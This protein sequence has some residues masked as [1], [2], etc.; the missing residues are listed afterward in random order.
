VASDPNLLPA[1]T[2]TPAPT[3]PSRDPAWSFWD[4]LFTALLAVGGSLVLAVLLGLLLGLRPQPDAFQPELIRATLVAQILA[5]GLVAAYV[6][7]LLVY[8]YRQPFLPAIRWNWPPAPGLWLLAGIGLSMAVTLAST[9]LPVPRGLP[10]ERYFTDRPL[11]FLM[12]F[13]GTAVAPLVEEVFFRGFL[14]PVLRNRL[15]I[16]TAIGVTAAVF[17]VIHSS[18]VDLAWAPLLLLF[19]VGLVLTTVR[20]RT[21]SVSAAFLI[22]LGYNATLFLLLALATQGFTEA[23]KVAP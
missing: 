11:A 7:S 14:Y 4:V 16:P 23:P 19:C 2:L 20:E 10:I 18:Q 22:H 6:Y 21:G 13:F 8:H 3:V 15:G 1:E 17:A 12:V 5:Y 9:Y